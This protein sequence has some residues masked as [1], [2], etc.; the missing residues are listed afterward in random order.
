MC[1]TCCA[2]GVVGICCVQQFVT[3]VGNRPF[4][5][6]WVEGEIILRRVLNRNVSE[7]FGVLQKVFHTSLK[8]IL[9]LRIHHTIENYEQAMG[10]HVL[11]GE[12]AF[13]AKNLLVKNYFAKCCS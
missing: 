6:L 10:C 4:G 12:Y 3:F 5:R 8:M 9:D 7:Y 1:S 11:K 13:G 2:L